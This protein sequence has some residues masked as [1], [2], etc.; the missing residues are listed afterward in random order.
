MKFRKKHSSSERDT[1][2]R[3]D[4]EKMERRLSKQRTSSGGVA[5]G[6]GKAIRMMG[7]GISNIGKSLASP[8]DNRRPRI[9]Q[10]PNSRHEIGI[11][12]HSDYNKLKAPGLRNKDISGRRRTK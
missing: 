1:A 2:S 10:L 11:S 9:A 3:K 12:Q 6:T 8:N 5:Q 7:R 4:L